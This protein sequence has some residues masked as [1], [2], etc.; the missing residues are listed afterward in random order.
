MGALAPLWGSNVFTCVCECVH[1]VV[2][3]HGVCT[4]V[5]GM[6]T[7]VHVCSCA[8]LGISISTDDLCQYIICTRLG[9]H[10]REA[11]GEW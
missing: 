6:C 7:H 3:E 11:C 10:V 1:T 4:Q 2:C 8:S 5:K 9:S